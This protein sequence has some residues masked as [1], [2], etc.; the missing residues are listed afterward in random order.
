M[1]NKVLNYLLL[2]SVTVLV[3]FFSL[4]DNYEEIISILKTLNKGWLLVACLL[5]FGYWFFKTIALNTIVKKFKSEFRFR[6]AFRLILEINFFN[7]ITPFASGGQPFQIYSLRKEK[8]KM[9]DCTTIAIQQFVVYQIALVILGVI[10]IICN[11]FFHMFPNNS[12]IKHLVT[13]GFIVNAVVTVA[14]FL[15]AFTKK[16]NK[17]IVNIGINLLHKF[18]IVKDKEKQTKKFNKYINELYDGTKLLLKN[19]SEFIGMIFINFAGLVCLYLVPLAILYGAGDYT[20]FNGLES[21][22][23]SAYV[24]L[25]GSFVPI[26]GGTGGLE[27]GFIKFYGN[28]IKGSV[29]TAIMITWRFITYYIPMIIGAIAVSITKKEKKI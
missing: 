24:M 6:K 29:L 5:I 23:A 2:L 12:V 14:L 21:V 7:A 18:K 19:K 15:L 16:I 27:F 9:A 1:K 22:I 10:A 20:S 17:F 25:I 8:I 13:I 4:K 11:H 3:L 28:F 26:P